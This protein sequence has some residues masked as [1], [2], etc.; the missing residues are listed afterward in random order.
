M[1]LTQTKTTSATLGAGIE[2]SP[3]AKAQPKME[4]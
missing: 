4:E 2:S 1:G 3:K